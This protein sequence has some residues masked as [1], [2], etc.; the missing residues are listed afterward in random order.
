VSVAR[1]S[2]QCC[3]LTSS[4]S[5][6]L[7]ALSAL[8]G[9]RTVGSARSGT[10][11]GDERDRCGGGRAGEHARPAA[12][13]PVRLPSAGGSGWSRRL[14]G[15]R[16]FSCR[17]NR[18][19]RGIQIR[20]RIPVTHQH[21][22]TG[23]LAPHQQPTRL[24]SYRTGVP[25][26]PPAL[27]AHLSLS[28]RQPHGGCRASGVRGVEEAKMNTVERRV[29]ATINPMSTAFTRWWC[30]SAARFALTGYGPAR[31]RAF[32]R[33]QRDAYPTRG[34]APATAIQRAENKTRHM[35]ARAGAVRRAEDRT[36]Q[37]KARARAIDELDL[38]A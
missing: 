5:W 17:D 32:P 2:A 27:G 31:R 1:R 36:E 4:C 18:F 30:H 10:D 22:R 8:A 3:R 35:K 33:S 13:H 37:M 6:A 24:A 7:A 38:R 28:R 29:R 21:C 26:R 9:D 25:A 16:H 19:D 14:P 15:R 23:A 11:D 12:R 34:A 20:H